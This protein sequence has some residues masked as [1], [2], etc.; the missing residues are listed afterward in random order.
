MMD[1]SS[2]VH[3]DFKNTLLMLRLSRI[4]YEDKCLKKA[5]FCGRRDLGMQ[6]LVMGAVNDCGC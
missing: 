1:I 6:R 5:H 2:G 3:D 4:K